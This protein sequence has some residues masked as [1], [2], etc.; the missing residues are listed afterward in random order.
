[1]RFPRRL[2]FRCPLCRRV[3]AKSFSRV[4]LGPGTHRCVHC[5]HVFPDGS[6]EWSSIARGVKMEYLF[7]DTLVVYTLV[8]LVAGAAFGLSALPHWRDV[9]LVATLGAALVVLP[10]FAHLIVCRVRIRQSIV[11]HQRAVMTKSGY[12]NAPVSEAQPR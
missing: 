5:Y 12:R 6:V 9:G 3:F 1:M 2:R 8:G 11:R 10:L 4:R 7:P